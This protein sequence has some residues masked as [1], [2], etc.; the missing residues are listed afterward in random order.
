MQ[1]PPTPIDETHRLRALTT[2]CILDTMPEDRFDRITR[3]ACRAFNVP[4]ALVT[5]IDRDRQWFKSRQGLE[6][7]ETSRQISFCGHTIIQEGPLHVPDALLDPRFADNPLVIGVPMIR[8]YAGQAVR[9]P[10]G[11]RIGTL[12]II[13]RQPRHMSA[14]DLTLLG[15][16]A[17]MIDREFSLVARAST[18]ELTSLANRRGF[19][20]V[21]MHVL[22]LC[23]RNRQSAVVIGIDINHFKCINDNHGHEAGDAVLRMFGKL[24]FANFRSSDVVARFGGDEFAILC[25]GMT[26]DEVWVSLERLRIEFAASALVQNY[27]GLSWSAGLADFNPASTETIED[28]LRTSD[29]RMYDAKMAS[30]QNLD[31]VGTP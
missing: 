16:L 26:S 27:P 31:T 19:T 8:F 17:A 1:A 12:C 6:S 13:D 18:D 2:L 14:E 28:L 4:I 20:E 24:L 30:R 22:A 7:R 11:S 9:G 21:A 29:A 3:L 10:D 5:L 23:R 25:G 15:D